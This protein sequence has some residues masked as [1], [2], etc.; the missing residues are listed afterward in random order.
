MKFKKVRF[1]VHFESIKIARRKKKEMTSAFNN[2]S[3]TPHSGETSSES[4]TKIIF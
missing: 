2:H 1:F 3:N 4:M